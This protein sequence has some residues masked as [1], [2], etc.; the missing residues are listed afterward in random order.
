MK[1]TLL[2]SVSLLLIASNFTSSAHAMG[3]VSGQA[4]KY[5]ESLTPY[6]TRASKLYVESVAPYLD[7]NNKTTQTVALALSGPAVIAS[8]IGISQIP[9]LVEEIQYSKIKRRL[10][11]MLGTAACFTA[12][13]L[14]ACKAVELGLFDATQDDAPIMLGLAVLGSGMIGSVLLIDTIGDFKYPYYYY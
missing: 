13:T 9:K 4:L 14:A 1:R 11:K 8:A 7:L 3:Q 10:A 12:S 2:L 5:M 6:L